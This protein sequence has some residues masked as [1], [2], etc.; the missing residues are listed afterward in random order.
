MAS[1]PVIIALSKKKILLM[2]TG[3]LAF[4]A[5]GVWFIVKP[6]VV[7]HAVFGNPT[8]IFSA[9]IASVL[10]FGL[11][12]VMLLRKLPDTTPGLVIDEAGLNDNSSG[13]AAGQIPWSDIDSFSVVEIQKQKII[14]VHVKH[15]QTYIERQSGSFKRKAMALNNKLYGTPVSITS[16]GLNI[17]FEELRAILTIRLQESRQ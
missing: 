11:C 2:L 6:P 3:S 14:L 9:G 12:A 10:F 15:P 7:H 1:E 13:V 16:N 17:G 4:V 8:L 5:I